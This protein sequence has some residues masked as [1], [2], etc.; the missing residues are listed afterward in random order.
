MAGDEIYMSE[1][2][3]FMI[4]YPSSSV[5]GNANELRKEAEILDKIGSIMLDSYHKKTGLA[6]EDLAKML[7]AETWFAQEAKDN[8]FINDIKNIVLSRNESV[9]SH[10]PKEIF[11]SFSMPINNHRIISALGLSADVSEIDIINKINSLKK[12]PKFRKY[13]EGKRISKK[14]KF[15]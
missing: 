11:A 7:D 15:R 1:N 13:R 8:K 14:S 9:N 2:A 4:H 12:R 5:S 10:N 3:V 6:K